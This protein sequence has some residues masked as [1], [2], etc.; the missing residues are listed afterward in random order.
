MVAIVLVGRRAVGVS[1]RQI[2]ATDRF[3]PL[4]TPMPAWA[5]G[6]RAV[7]RKQADP[8]PLMLGGVRGQKGV[9]PMSR[10]KPH[11][12]HAVPV[13][14]AFALVVVGFFVLGGPS[15]ESEAASGG[16]TIPSTL[17]RSSSTTAAPTTAAPTTA[18]PTTAA[19]TTAPP[20]TAAPAPTVPP[21]TAPPATQPPA[22]VVAE[23]HGACG[24][25]LPPCCVMLRESGGDPTAVN[26]SS[27]ASG[28]WQFMSDTWQGFDGYNSA[29]EAPES[30][31]DARA[32]QIWAGGSGAG[33]WGG[34]C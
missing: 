15:I 13:V 30:V 26:A 8:P 11:A 24:G 18:V 31:Q 7:R 27:G 1:L 9:R 10:F 32:A 25:N 17:V 19:P 29:A 12:V 14:L 33:H 6:H 4:P 21:Q 23:V 20:T 3:R 5:P 2:V 28:K 16:S 22:P 34:G